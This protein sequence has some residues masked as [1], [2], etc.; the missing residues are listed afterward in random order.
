MINALAFGFDL[1]VATNAGNVLLYGAG[2]KPQE[3][4]AH[5]EASVTA[6]AFSLDGRK[7][8]TGGGFGSVNVWDSESLQKTTAL[9]PHAGT[10]WR[11]L[12]SADGD[13]LVSAASDGTVRVWNLEP[14]K[15]RTLT[16]MWELRGLG[17]PRLPADFT[18]DDRDAIMKRYAP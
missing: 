9:P 10:V 12:L 2:D 17:D 15:V 13:T 18:N 3:L 6:V 8:A 16:S 5:P 14:A 1:A 11:V 4:R 7:L